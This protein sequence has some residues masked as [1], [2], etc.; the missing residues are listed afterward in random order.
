MA[1]SD[2]E[3][4]VSRSVR[5]LAFWLKLQGSCLSVWPVC[6]AKKKSRALRNSGLVHRFS[7]ASER[8]HRASV[9]RRGEDRDMPLFESVSA[10]E[11]FVLPKQSWLIAGLTLGVSLV[12][13]ALAF[14]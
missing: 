14:A 6:I 9:R 13:V 11:K 1:E 2:L 4:A 5:P 7:L 10:N 8:A 12:A 3:Q